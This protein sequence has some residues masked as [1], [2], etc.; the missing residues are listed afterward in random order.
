[1]AGLVD[2]KS[3]DNDLFTCS[4]NGKDLSKYMTGYSITEQ[5]LHTDDSGRNETGSMVIN[6]LATKLKF[7][8]SVSDCP[9][10][11]I[12]HI[13]D[14]FNSGTTFPAK[15]RVGTQIIETNFKIYGGDRKFS[16]SIHNGTLDLWNAEFSIIEI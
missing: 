3:I 7:S 1:M 9:A 11:Y 13:R 15:C 16:Q 12:D 5:D 2:P 6:K 10:S 8:I 4:V 14:T